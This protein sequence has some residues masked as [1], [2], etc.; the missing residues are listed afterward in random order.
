MPKLHPIVEAAAAVLFDMDGVLADTEPTHLDALRVVLARRGKSM[1][2]AQYL[3]LIGL[4]RADSWKWIVSHYGLTEPLEDLGTEYED[5]LEALVARGLPAEPGVHE[6]IE[7][8]QGRGMPLALA[9][10]SVRR[11][12]D[13]QL[14]ALHLEDAFSV[15][16]SGDDVLTGKPDPA[17][18]VEAARR[19]GVACEGCVVIE[20]S[21]AGIE[22]GRRAGMK[23]VAVRTRYTAGR[24]LPADLVVDSLVE[25]LD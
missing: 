2:D 4:K 5:E 10:S 12:I 23:V 6:L 19:L 8:L 25:L 16:V 11:Q 18:F 17:V 24:E 14:R 7:A 20:D 3:P 1:T 22:A 13:M 15:I 21:V 9:S